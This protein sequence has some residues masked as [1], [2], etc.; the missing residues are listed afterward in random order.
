MFGSMRAEVDIRLSDV[1]V[2]QKQQYFAA[3]RGGVRPRH[4]NAFRGVVA[5]KL[6]DSI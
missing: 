5:A 2:C 4:A 3:Y 1:V 6:R